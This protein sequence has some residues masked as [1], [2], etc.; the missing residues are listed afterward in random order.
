MA[1]KNG[2]PNPL[3]FFN[4]R[5]VYVCAPHFEY[6]IVQKTQY[7]LVKKINK[8]IET[9]LNKRYYIDQNISVDHNNS[10]VYNIKIGFEDKKELSF[11]LLTCPFIM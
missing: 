1:L 11:F 6:T 5:R 3:N 10:F 2:I 7:H 4:L 8:W 9:N